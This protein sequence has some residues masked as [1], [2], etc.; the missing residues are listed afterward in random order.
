MATDKIPTMLRLPE[1]LH[2]KI[3]KLAT[4]EHRSMNMQMEF[5]IS[6]YIRKYESEHGE[7][8]PD[9]YSPGSK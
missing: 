3:K 7:I 8:I 5:A 4:L 9:D 1:D 2:Y 6:E